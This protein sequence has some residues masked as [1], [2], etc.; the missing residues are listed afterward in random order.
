MSLRHERLADEVRD[1]LATNF[2]AG[3]MNDPRLEQVSITAVRL[4]KDLQVAYVYFRAMAAD[5]SGAITSTEKEA[6]KGLDSAAGYLR[7]LLAERLSVRRVPT[8][9]FFFDET[10]DRADRIHGLLSNLT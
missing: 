3:R 9:K 7:N 2:M 6:Q 1:I 10:L 5:G 8:L 4:S